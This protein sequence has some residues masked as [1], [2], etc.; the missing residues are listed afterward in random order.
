MIRIYERAGSEG[1]RQE[2][3]RCTRFPQHHIREGLMEGAHSLNKNVGKQ[4][5]TLINL[6]FISSSNRRKYQLCVSRPKTMPEQ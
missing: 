4:P 1:G 3:E 6:Y 5:G 2:N